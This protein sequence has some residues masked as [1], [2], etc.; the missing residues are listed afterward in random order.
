MVKPKHFVVIGLGTFGAALAARMSENGCRVTGV[1]IAK[2]T[3]EELK[4]S[5]YEPLIGDATEQSTLQHLALADAEAVFISLGEDITRS[6]LAT[7]HAR[8]AGAKRIIV[9]GVT[10][11]HGKLLKIMGVERVVFP[12]AE[13]AEEMADRMTRP[14]VI[15]FLPIDPE[16]G[17]I[18]VAAPDSFVGKT[19]LELNL[20][21]K[22]DV[23]VV[24]VK[25]TMSGDMKIIPHGD[26]KIGPDQVLLLLGKQE[27]LDR[28]SQ[29]T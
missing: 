11:E 12:E 5:L 28:L 19:L 13:I 9:K 27:D 14:N 10:R 25:D 18:E 21:R 3:V 20:R 16:Y 26:F 6:L 4:D 15:D 7:L 23:W 8:E 29:K 2:E 22:Y 17:F 24:G 1:D